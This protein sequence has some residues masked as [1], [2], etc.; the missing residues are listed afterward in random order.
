MTHD[1]YAGYAIITTA[2]I[3]ALMFWWAYLNSGE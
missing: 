1:A 2:C 3:A